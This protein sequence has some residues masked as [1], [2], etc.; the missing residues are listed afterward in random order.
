MKCIK[1]KITDTEWKYNKVSDSAA[2]TMQKNGSITLDREDL[3]KVPVG[4]SVYIS[5]SEYKRKA[6]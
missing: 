4:K 3:T 5:K 6:E 1:T 2:L